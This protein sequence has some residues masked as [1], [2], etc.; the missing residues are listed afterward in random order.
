MQYIEILIKEK[1]SSIDPSLD[2]Q[3]ADRKMLQLACKDFGN[4]MKFNNKTTQY[5]HFD[6]NLEKLPKEELSE[7]ESFLTIW[8]AKWMKKWQERIKLLIGN[9]RKN[10]LSQLYQTLAKADPILQTIEYKQ[11]LIDIVASSLINNGEICCSDIL[12][13]HAVKLELAKNHLN[14]SDKAQTLT[15]LNNV[16]RRANEMAKNSGPLLF[17]MISKAY[18]DSAKTSSP[19]YVKN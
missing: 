8:T 6:E 14:I 1:I 2:L 4:Y 15:F 11:E 3:D 5:M 9:N 19:L 10:E 7:L 12:A 17:I 13:E 16:L 18:Y